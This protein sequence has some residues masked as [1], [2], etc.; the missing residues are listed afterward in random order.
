MLAWGGDLNPTGAGYLQGPTTVDSSNGG[1]TFI[2]VATA[3]TITQDD[4]SGEANVNDDATRTATRCYMRGL[5]ERIEIKTTDSTPWRWRR[6]MFTFKGLDLLESRTAPPAP[7]EPF[8]ETS[9]GYVRLMAQISNTGNTE[10]VALQARIYQHLFKGVFNKDWDNVMNA[11]TAGKHI[12]ILSDKLTH[13]KSGNEQG[14][15][16]T[17]RRWYPFNNTLVYDDYEEGGGKGAA[18]LSAVHPDSMGDVYIV[19]F[20]EPLND[21]ADG[22]IFWPSASLY[23]HER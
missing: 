6:I 4:S 19:D 2:W 14:V 23:W 17:V 20:F 9:S 7:I 10:V 8:L 3:R 11:K 5:K 13:I 21:A 12:N 18:S 22:L 1:E 16:R 15:F